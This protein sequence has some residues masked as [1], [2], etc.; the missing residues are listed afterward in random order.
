MQYIRDNITLGLNHYD[1]INDAPLSELLRQAS[2]NTEIQLMTFSDYSWKECPYND[3]STEAYII[4]DQIGTINHGTH[5]PG[6][7]AQS[8]A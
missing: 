8:S 3:R 7:V 2:I 1:D 6:L 5:V 4:F